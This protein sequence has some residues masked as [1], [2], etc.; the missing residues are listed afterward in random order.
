MED[1]VAIVFVL[2]YSVDELEV[3]PLQLN[4]NIRGNELPE[5]R[6]FYA[7][8]VI[9][10]RTGKQAITNECS[11]HDTG[12]KFVGGLAVLPKK[13]K[14]IK[15]HEVDKRFMKYELRKFGDWRLQVMSLNNKNHA[16]LFCNFLGIEEPFGGSWCIVTIGQSYRNLHKFCSFRWRTQFC[17]I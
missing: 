8:M 6:Q 1:L 3:A 14:E 2:R 5:T 17:P 7:G 10:V 15:M 13:R 9:N 4:I 11:V 12:M 16:C